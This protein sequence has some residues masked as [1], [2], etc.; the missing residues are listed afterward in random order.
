M[1][2]PDLAAA[3]E[4]Y[5]AR[6]GHEP[7]CPNCQTLLDAAQRL[8]ELEGVREAAAAH[9]RELPT[10][11]GKW[12]GGSGGHREHEPCNQFA[13]YG[14]QPYAYC[15]EHATEHMDLVQLLDGQALYALRAALARVGGGT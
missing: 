8:R 9:V 2:T 4:A 11:S 6:I 1:T 3:L 14:D 7:P 13:V 10:C 5:A 12:T 15:N